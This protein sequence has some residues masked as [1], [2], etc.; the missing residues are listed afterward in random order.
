MRSDSFGLGGVPLRIAD[1]KYPHPL[2]LPTR[3]R[4]R[5]R[6]TP[7]SRSNSLSRRGEE[8]FAACAQACGEVVA[9]GVNG[10]DLLAER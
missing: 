3:G 5:H 10:A 7:T 1:R 8:V 6:R 9:I 4:G 2:Y